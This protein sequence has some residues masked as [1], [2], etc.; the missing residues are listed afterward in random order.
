MK[1]QIFLADWES[2]KKANLVLLAA[3]AVMAAGNGF[4]AVDMLNTKTRVVLVPPRLTRQAKIGYGSASVPYYKA[5]GMYVSEMLGNLTP[6][7]EGF[8]AK[9]LLP[10]MDAQTYQAVKMGLQAEKDKEI[11]Y[12]VTTSFDATSII[13][14]PLTSTIF[15]SGYLHQI[16]P[17]GRYVSGGAQTFQ[18]NITVENGQPVISAFE[19]YPG[20]PHTLAWIEHHPKGNGKK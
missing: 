17:S 7:N 11:E 5:W 19:G 8:V 4:L 12:H 18:M 6:D 3:L 13:W 14:Q 20:A 15:V 1:W 9:S 2:T 10:L 16:S